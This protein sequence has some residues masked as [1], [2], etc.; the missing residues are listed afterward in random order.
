[1]LGRHFELLSV[2]RRYIT[3]N[4]S[5]CF[6]LASYQWPSGEMASR[7]TTNQEIVG[8]T[9]TSV[10]LQLA[11]LL[12]QAIFLFDFIFASVVFR[13]ATKPRQRIVSVGG[14]ILFFSPTEIGFQCS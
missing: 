4:A 14:W 5:E 6:D 12:A 2:I 3:A 8:S 10:T 1:M 13:A 7:L 11:T 9:P